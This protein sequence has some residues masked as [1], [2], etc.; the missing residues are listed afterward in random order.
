LDAHAVAHFVRQEAPRLSRVLSDD[1]TTVLNLLTRER[2][3]IQ[4]DAGWIR[5]QIHALLAQLDPEYDQHLPNLGTKAGMRAL[6][7]Y[8][9]IWNRTAS[10]GARRVRASAREATP[11]SRG[12]NSRP[13]ETDSNMRCTG[14]ILSAHPHLWSQSTKRRGHWRESSVPAGAS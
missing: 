11:R 5:N 1:A 7:T 4:A 10:G 9:G 2:T 8:Q 3:S 13:C 14:R 6:A 12:P